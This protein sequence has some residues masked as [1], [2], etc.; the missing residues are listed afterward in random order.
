[1]RWRNVGASV[2]AGVVCAATAGGLWVSL[3]IWGQSDCPDVFVL[4]VLTGFVGGWLCALIDRRRPLASAIVGLLALATGGAVALGSDAVL[5]IASAPSALCGALLGAPA[6]RR[7][8]RLWYVAALVPVL[9]TSLPVGL[10]A[11]LD[12]PMYFAASRY[13]A[14]HS[15]ELA[16]YCRK[17][18]ATFPQRA[19]GWGIRIGHVKPVPPVA[20]HARFSVAEGRCDVTLGTGHYY[21]PSFTADVMSVRLVFHPSSPTLVR[22]PADVRAM[23]AVLGV[24]V[25][26]PA[27]KWNAPDPTGGKWWVC[28]G[29]PRVSYSATATPQGELEFEAAP[30][31]PLSNPPD[32]QRPA[33]QESDL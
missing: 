18:I 4:P 5:A 1:M 2:V 32:S 17:Y 27:V 9:G 10:L 28:W 33:G 3:M 8:G 30:S 24:A 31:Q 22:S 19:P 7:L 23:L 6:A 20:F 15:D 21:E 14:Q 12:A 26:G 16:A 13:R 29:A 25:P 11:S